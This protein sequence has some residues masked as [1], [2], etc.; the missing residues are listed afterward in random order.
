MYS[1]WNSLFA[2]GTKKF[3]IRSRTTITA[4]GSARSTLHKTSYLNANQGV[5]ISKQTPAEEPRRPEKLQLLRPDE[6]DGLDWINN[7]TASGKKRRPSRNGRG[8]PAV[9]IKPLPALILDVPLVSLQRSRSRPPRP[10]AGQV[11]T[12]EVY[13]AVLQKGSSSHRSWTA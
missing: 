11:V 12:H 8:I 4:S 6:H 10:V 13:G 5:L 3:D 7:P 9:Q 1:P 2:P